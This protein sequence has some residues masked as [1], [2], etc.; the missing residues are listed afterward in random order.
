MATLLPI[1]STITQ[2]AAN[3]SS[4]YLLHTAPRWSMVISPCNPRISNLISNKTAN[5]ATSSG[6]SAAN[7]VALGTM[8]AG[9]TTIATNIGAAKLYSHFHNK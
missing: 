1:L 6:V 4:I 7:A 5:V 8:T 3:I 9:I 2:V